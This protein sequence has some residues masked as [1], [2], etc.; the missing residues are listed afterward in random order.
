M[1][2]GYGPAALSTADFNGDGHSDLVVAEK[3]TIPYP[4]FW[5]MAMA[6]FRGA[7]GLHHRNVS[8]VGCR[9]ATLMAI[10]CSIWQSQTR[11]VT[12][13]RSS[14]ETPIRRPAGQPPSA[15]ASFGAQVPYPAGTSPTSIAVADFNIDG[16][17]N[18]AVTSMGDNAISLLLNL[19][20]GT[21]GP[22]FELPVGTSPVS[23]VTA[24]FNGDGR[25]DVAAT[26]NGSGDVSVILNSSNFSPT[27]SNAF[28]GH[29]IPRGSIHRHRLEGEGD[30]ANS[31]E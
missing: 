28:H 15:T 12:R 6:R 16:L 26:N 22:N 30:T 8:G 27:S 5:A 3:G 25:P 2:A 7:H 18:L 31:F 29:G 21:F 20:G 10:R 24:D 11:E 23:I 19:G 14:S 13:F 1:P 17:P 4:Y 9:Q